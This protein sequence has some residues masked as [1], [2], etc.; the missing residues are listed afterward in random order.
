MRDPDGLG[1]G[2]GGLEPDAP[3]LRRQPVGLVTDHRDG[4]AGVLLVDPHRQRRGHPDAGQEHHHFLDRLLLLP[5]VGDLLGPFGSQSVHLGQPGGLGLDDGQ[6]VGAEMRHHPLG[7]HRA[8]PLDHP[9]TQVA[10]DALDGGGQHGGIRVHLELPAVPGV[11][12]PAPGQAQA[13]AD[14][15]AQQRPHHRQQIRAGPLGGHPGDGVAGVLVGVGDPFQDRLQHRLARRHTRRRGLTGH[16]DHSAGHPQPR[17]AAPGGPAPRPGVAAA[18]D[19][20]TGG[21]RPCPDFGS[22]GL[23]CVRPRCALHPLSLLAERGVVL[24]PPGTRGQPRG[25]T[26]RIT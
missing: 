13:L 8:D 7:H 4:G 25:L 14:L 26:P 21:A 17:S 20:K 5:G 10:A 18:G 1:D 16:D 9:R 3:H 24:S 12:A 11:G 6:D 19:G 23:W 2:V 22:G 15:G